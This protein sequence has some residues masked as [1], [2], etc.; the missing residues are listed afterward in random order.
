LYWADHNTH[1]IERLSQA[2]FGEKFKLNIDGSRLFLIAP[3]FNEDVKI[4]TGYLKRSISVEL[5]SYKCLK[6]ENK[7]GILSVKNR[8]TDL[9]KAVRTNETKNLNLFILPSTDT[10][11]FTTTSTLY[12]AKFLG[13]FRYQMVYVLLTL[14]RDMERLR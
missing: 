9:N 3:A 1:V 11:Y 2:K 10:L 13:S 14:L 8:K 6:F 4:L 5:F 7:K 12:S